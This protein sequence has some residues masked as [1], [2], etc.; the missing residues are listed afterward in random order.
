MRRGKK[1]LWNHNKSMIE[2]E[3]VSVEDAFKLLH[4]VTG[5]TSD[6]FSHITIKEVDK[7]LHSGD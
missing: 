5:L 4:K 7:S 3:T 6:N 1:E 2:Y